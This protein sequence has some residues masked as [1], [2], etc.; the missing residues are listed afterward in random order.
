MKIYQIIKYPNNEIGT[1]ETITF[2]ADNS[3]LVI[4]KKFGIQALPGTRVIFDDDESST[5]Q[6][7]YTGVFEFSAEDTSLWATKITIPT[8]SLQMNQ[9]AHAAIILDVIY[10]EIERSVV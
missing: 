8:D 9:N 4:I 10:E 7:G 3:K 1:N 6:V 2:P 5:I